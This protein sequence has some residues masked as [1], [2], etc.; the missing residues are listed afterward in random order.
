[1][2][3][4]AYSPPLWLYRFDAETVP[5]THVFILGTL[6]A[7]ARGRCVAAALLAFAVFLARPDTSALTLVLWGCAGVCAHRAGR[8]RRWAAACALP[9]LAYAGYNFLLFRSLVPPG[10]RLAP[11]VLDGLELYR[12]RDGGPLLGTLSE[13]LNAGYF[14]ARAFTGFEAVRTAQFV[15]YH[16][17]WLLLALAGGARAHL[18]RDACALAVW[19]AF[20]I[21]VLAPS[22]LSPSVF[23]SWRTLHPLL[24]LLISSAAFA[25]DAVLVAAIARCRDV[26]AARMLAPALVSAAAAFFALKMLDGLQPYLEPPAP[27]ALAAAYSELA[28]HLDGRAVMSQA[29]WF[30]LSSTRRPAVNLPINGD[31]AVIAAIERYHVGWLIVPEDASCG[32]DNAALCSALVAGARQ[33]LGAY[34]VRRSAR[35][36]GQLLFEIGVTEGGASQ[37]FSG[38]DAA[39][40]QLGAP[41]G[42]S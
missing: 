28:T 3:L 23:A 21:G 33:N 27:P 11:W 15:P 41:G 4:F 30:V 6:I 9:V 17:V 29:P 22:W 2:L 32:Q 34:S 1:L 38:A 35:A 19:L 8:L 37:S 5:W 7:L 31:A 18:R 16:H 25:L 14:E 20:P 40:L 10:A 13:R 39:R 36:G 26:I 42:R 24:P 12:Y